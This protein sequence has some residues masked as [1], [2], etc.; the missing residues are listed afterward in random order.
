MSVEKRGCAGRSFKAVSEPVSSFV[1]VW[2]LTPQ[3][4]LLQRGGA[5]LEQRYSDWKGAVSMEYGVVS[6]ET[7]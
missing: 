3:S 6:S 7:S 5:E 4:P 1:L 2:G